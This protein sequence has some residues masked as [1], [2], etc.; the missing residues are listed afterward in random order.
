MKMA[1]ILF[2]GMVF[3]NFLFLFPF[4]SMC[5]EEKVSTFFI[6]PHIYEM[7]ILKVL[8]LI[9]STV[10]KTLNTRVRCVNSKLEKKICILGRLLGLW[11][12]KYRTSIITV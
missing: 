4:C 6:V 11:R 12:L 8:K 10:Y 3:L 1:S 5:Y 9:S 2:D 7:H